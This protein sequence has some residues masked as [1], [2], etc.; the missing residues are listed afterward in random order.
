LVFFT[1]PKRLMSSFSAVE[2][3]AARFWMSLAADVSVS[4]SNE[5]PNSSSTTHSPLSR[6]ARCALS[7]SSRPALVYFSVRTVT[8]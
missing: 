3:A 2:M 8:R 1:D 5:L 7:A 6:L 4:A